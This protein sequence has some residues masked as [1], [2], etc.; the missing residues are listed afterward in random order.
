MKKFLKIILVLFLFV[1]LALAVFVFTFDAN[2]YKEEVA[3]VIG[4]IVSRPV[5]ISGDVDISIYP[6]IG[7]KLNEV[8]I[9]NNS[10]FSKKQMATIGQFD[11][12][13]KI[14]PLLQKKLDID[15]LVM[16]RLAVDFEKNANGENNWSDFAADT[17]S[18]SVESKYG[19]A[20]LIIGSIELTD[21]RLGWL[22]VATGKQFKISRLNLE[23]SEI[24][25]GHSLPLD[26]KAYVESNQPEWQA[27]ISAKSELVFSDDSAEFEANNLKLSVKALVPGETMDTVSF[28]MVT[29]SKINWQENTA[30]LSKTK[31]SIFGLILSGN[32]DVDNLFSTPTIQGALKVK[33]F[34]ASK[35]AE[36]FKLEIPPMADA[37]SLK[38]IS[39]TTLFKTDFDKIYMDD[40]YAN[41]DKSRVKGFVHI[42]NVSK[43]EIRYALEVDAVAL[44]DYKVANSEADAGDLPLAFINSSWLEGTLD[45]KSSMV[46]DVE[47]TDLHISTRIEDGVMVANPVTMWLG[48]SEVKAAVQVDARSTLQT[49]LVINA[50]NVDAETSINPLLK[51]IIGDEAPVM[52][53]LLNIDADIKASGASFAEQKLSAAGTVKIAM[54]DAKVRGIDLN[55]T[56]R[57][58]V[59]DYANR[60]DF[61]TRATYVPKYE[62]DRDTEISRLQAVF[63]VSKGKLMNSDLLINTENVIV[64]GSGSID[65]IN[66]KLDYSPIIDVIVLNRVDIRDKLRDHPMEYRVQGPF[67]NPEYQ[68][69]VDRYDLLVGRLLLQEAKARRNRQINNAR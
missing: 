50:K 56:S 27:A 6:W 30:K 65:F 53:G 69:E 18:D 35:P 51:T 52:Q 67:G 59:A 12:S 64:S 23:T 47:L 68:F 46:D 36:Y 55:Y 2:K 19:L 20:G 17:G 29:D 49:G 34:D 42:D 48:D 1:L 13:V 63:K 45:I 11:V 60:N 44:H 31:F 14:I 57:S 33:A 3:E 22:D 21:A 62:P 16:H 24:I 54:Q 5:S 25:K 38:N 61:H 66:K 8:T 15:K 28:A 41:V 32:F 40:I 39:L 43:P 9:E 4:S 37:K 58:I 26:L 10:G 7:I